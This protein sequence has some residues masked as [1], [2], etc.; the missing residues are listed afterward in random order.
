MK[1]SSPF[2]LGLCAVFA[3]TA[4]LIACNPDHQAPGVS[5][6]PRQVLSL[7]DGWRFFKGDVENGA[8]ADSGSW[9]AISVPHTFNALDGQDGGTYYRGPTWYGRSI[10]TTVGRGQKAF[11]RFEGSS[12]VSD[13]YLDGTALG[14][15]RGAFGAFAFDVTRAL[16][17]TGR[18]ELRVKVDNTRVDDV[19]PLSGDFTLFGGIYRPV[20]LIVTGEICITPLDYA[21]PGVYL[22]QIHVSAARARVLASTKVLNGSTIDQSVSVQVKVL[23]KDGTI[24]TSA[25][26]TALVQAGVTQAID[27][28]LDITSP[29]LWAGRAD[30]YL[31]T[32]EVSTL[33]DGVVTDSIVQ[34]LGLRTF[35][36]NK[37]KGFTLNGRP[38]NIRGVNRHQDREGMGWAIGNAE[39]DEDMALIKEVGANGVR[40]AHYQQSDYFY[41]LADKEGI[42]A[43]AEI[44]V[45]NVVKDTQ[46]FADNAKQQL[47]EMIRQNYNHPSIFAWGLFNEIYL[48]PSD[49]AGPLIF[50]L[51]QLAKKEDHSRPDVAA[52]FAL[53]LD[54]NAVPTWLCANIYPGWYVGEATTALAQSMID[55]WKAEAQR[56]LCLGE[57]GAGANVTQHAEDPVTKPG[58]ND[59]PFHPEEY[60]SITHE[61]IYAAVVDNPGLWGTFLWN[62]FDFASDG[63]NEGG[64]AGRNDKGI[65]TYDRKIRKDAFF[66]YKANWRNDEP[67]VYITGR[68]LTTR[69]MASMQV[70]VYS[71]CAAVELFVDDVS[72]GRATPSRIKVALFPDVKL[73]VG[74]HTVKA[75]GQCEGQ[76]VEDSVNWVRQ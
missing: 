73:A 3:A 69:T 62:M 35:A 43:W 2:S 15:H 4:L 64:Q 54:V 66:F 47:L 60:Q 26:N 42:L 59:A 7:N 52:T 36:A 24:V 16:A 19:A 74:P 68:R 65:V 39:Q 23:A 44:P 21:S 11:L 38:Y 55:D 13:A 8:T 41:S 25:E 1:C 48:I 32:V 70:K 72:V 40:L 27:A 6:S 33:V 67:V 61:A 71:N 14:Q 63:R 12:L 10:A 18:G 22:R 28:L 58:Q 56:P 75:V 5:F 17:A 57:Y 51:N 46:A 9:E 31:Y 30:P 49:T 76:T 53:G 34:P 50:E 37:D 20:Q 29:H 45:V